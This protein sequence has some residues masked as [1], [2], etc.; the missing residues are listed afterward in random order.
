MGRA[1]FGS[2]VLR[3]S[4]TLVVEDQDGVFSVASSR[5]GV[6]GEAVVS[7]GY[8]SIVDAGGLLHLCLEADGETSAGT[9]EINVQGI[10]RATEIRVGAG[11]TIDGNGTIEGTVI[12][13]GGSISEGITIVP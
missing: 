10:L 12:D 11:C 13:L 9:A 5:A 1:G 6:T 8:D 3:G 2:L 4:S 7:I